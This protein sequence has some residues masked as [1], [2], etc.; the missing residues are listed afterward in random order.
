[1]TRRLLY[2]TA[3]IALLVTGAWIVNQ[4][5][6]AGDRD[7]APQD[8]GAGMMSG[9][10]SMHGSSEAGES[11]HGSGS[12]MGSMHGGCMMKGMHGSGMMKGT[13]GPGMMMGG[14]H[15][16]GMMM[17]MGGTPVLAWMNMGLDDKQV[18]KLLDITADLQRDQIPH[19]R[20]IHQLQ[21]ELAELDPDDPADID[22][23]GQIR[24][25]L[26][27][28]EV[29]LE[30]SRLDAR[31]SAMDVLTDEQAE[32]FGD[33]FRF[34]GTKR[35]MCKMMKGGMMHGGDWDEMPMYE[36]EDDDD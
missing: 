8:H 32:R 11:M 36:H 33:E 31:S 35:S 9:H 7:D 30:K 12:M 17:G 22:R 21:S 14:M 24:V 19:L 1:M 20:E 15:G 5:A 6:F 27:E 16:P 26:V 2:V 10:G 34:P 28:T 25:Q 29:A 18:T 4:A 13:H 3:L 23:R